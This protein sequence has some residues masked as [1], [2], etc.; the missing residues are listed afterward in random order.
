MRRVVGPVVFADWLG[1]L[2]PDI[3]IGG[4]PAEWLET[5]VA[6]DASDG[7]LMHLGGLNLS[8]AWMLEGIAAGLPE[9]DER[10]SIL[11]AAAV[12]HRDDGLAVVT[13][14]YYEGEHWL[15]TFATYLVTAR[16]LR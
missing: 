9:G 4:D 14:G 15:G 16:G 10:R 13:G 1:E 11:L 2:L 5:V 6:S 3:S 8:R 7:Q 12:Q